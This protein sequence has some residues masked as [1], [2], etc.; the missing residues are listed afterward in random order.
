M[1]TQKYRSIL[2]VENDHLNIHKSTRLQQNPIIANKF[3][4]PQSVRYNR[5]WLC[6]VFTFY[7]QR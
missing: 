6:V 3:G 5:D 2:L 1:N 4:R 7:S